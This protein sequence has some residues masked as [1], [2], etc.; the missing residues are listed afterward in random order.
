MP[1]SARATPS[2]SPACCALSRC[3]S[4]SESPGG[5]PEACGAAG[6]AAAAAVAQQARFAPTPRAGR[7]H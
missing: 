6:A 1:S 2:V 4:T 3:A 7:Q 5:A